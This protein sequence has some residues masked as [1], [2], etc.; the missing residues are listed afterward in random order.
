MTT[1]QR[2]HLKASKKYARAVLFT[3]QPSEYDEINE[4]AL[5]WGRNRVIF[6]GCLVMGLLLVTLAAIAAGRYQYANLNIT[7]S[8]SYVGLTQNF[9]HE[10]RQPASPLLAYVL[11]IVWVWRGGNALRHYLGFKRNLDIAKLK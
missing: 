2:A 3:E 10:P 7:T 1:A 11:A 9:F 8:G 5:E 4:R 6:F